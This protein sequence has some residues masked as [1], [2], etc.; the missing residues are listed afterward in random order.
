MKKKGITFLNKSQGMLTQA[1]DL[2]NTNITSFIIGGK[3]NDR[4]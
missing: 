1:N 3:N 4:Y 2:Y